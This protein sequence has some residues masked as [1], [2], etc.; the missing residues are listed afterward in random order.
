MLL[1]NIIMVIGIL[2]RVAFIT[3]YERKILGYIQIRQ[4]PNKVR[5]IGIFQPFCDA[6]KLFSKEVLLLEISNY[7]IYYVCALLRLALIIII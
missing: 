5:I 4:G 7:I 2:I 3:L 6:I 1:E